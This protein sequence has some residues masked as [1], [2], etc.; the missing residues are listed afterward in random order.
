MKKKI[1][2]ITG[3]SSGLG[4]ALAHTVIERGDFVVGTFRQQ[5]QVDAFNATHAGKAFALKMDIANAE[6]IHTGM[7]VLQEKFGCVDVLVNNAGYGLAGAIEETSIEE[8]RAIFEANFFGTLIVTQQILPIMRQQRQGHIVQVSSHGGFHAFAG[9]GIYNASKFAVEGFSEALAK[10]VAPL[11]IT[12]IIAEPGP[13]RTQFAGN[14]F[15]LAHT[16]IEDYGDTAGVFRQRIKGVDG[17]QEGDPTKAAEAIYDRVY[18]ENT[19]LRLPLGKIAIQTITTKI[20]SVQ[21]DIEQYRETAE[22]VVF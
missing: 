4:Q 13:F 11:D 21:N 7:S 3:I 1:W 8:T 6:S 20:T 12:V 18:S 17:K 10:E 19:A 2:F 15:A 9:F 5:H 14:N 16:T 22:S